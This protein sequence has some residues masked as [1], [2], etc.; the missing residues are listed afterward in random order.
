MSGVIDLVSVFGQHVQITEDG[1]GVLTYQPF[2]PDG[3]PTFSHLTLSHGGALA[4]AAV[5]LTT[6]GFEAV[7]IQQVTDPSGAT[8]THLLGQ[9][10]TE[11]GRIDP[12]PDINL[13]LG[14]LVAPQL[15]ALDGGR[16]LLAYDVVDKTTGVPTA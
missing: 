8:T 6:T 16:F 5:P 15:L 7:W 11:E 12:S 4:F 1:A 9:A 13:P 10:I 14:N 3:E 2:Q